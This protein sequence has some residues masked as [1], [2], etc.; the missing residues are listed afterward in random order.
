MNL[1]K[2]INLKN[3]WVLIGLVI[4]SDL[5]VFISPL[6]ELKEKFTN[7]AP[8][9]AVAI[10]VTEIL[11]ILGLFIMAYSVGHSLGKNIFKWKKQLKNIVKDIPDNRLLWVG[12]WT[13][14]IGAVGTGIAVGVAIIKILPPQSWGLLWLAF[15]DL[16]ITLAIRTAVWELKEEYS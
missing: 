13:N 14:T 16:G 8:E 15:I 3:K 5:L 4:A 9:F 7:Q 12:F 11:F 6:G 1:H 10:L 2:K